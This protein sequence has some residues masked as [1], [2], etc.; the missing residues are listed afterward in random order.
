MRG[1]GRYWLPALAAVLVVVSF[2]G[3]SA[4]AVDV[5]HGIAFTKGCTSPVKIGD[6][7]RCSFTIQNLPTVDQALDT[8][9]IFGLEDTVQ[10]AGGPVSSGPIFGSVQL[11]V[12]GGASCTAA[13][14]NG[15]AATPYS[16]A[17][18]CLLPTGSS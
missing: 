6:Q 15:T 12:S 1:L 13:A 7:Y 10:S 14:G 5:Q 11:T 8:L 17:T 4:F 16:G 9:E 18:S 2:G 3:G